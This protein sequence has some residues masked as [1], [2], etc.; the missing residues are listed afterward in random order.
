MRTLFDVQFFRSLGMYHGNTAGLIERFSAQMRAHEP[1]D[2]EDR[3]EASVVRTMHWVQAEEMRM[4][5]AI[6]YP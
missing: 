4:L 1:F 2:G 3:G 5:D 6:F